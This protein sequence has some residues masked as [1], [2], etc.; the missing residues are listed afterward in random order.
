MMLKKSV[1]GVA[2]YDEDDRIEH[3]NGFSHCRCRNKI[4]DSGSNSC[5]KFKETETVKL[6]KRGLP[7]DQQCVYNIFLGYCEL[8]RLDEIKLIKTTP[9]NELHLLANRVVTEKGVALLQQSLFRDLE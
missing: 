2:D 8:S 7:A 4:L 6:R 9:S 3:I 5:P 1:K